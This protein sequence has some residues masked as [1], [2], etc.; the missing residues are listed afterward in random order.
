[1]PTMLGRG[2]CGGHLT[3]VFTIEDSS[4][5]LLW[6]GSRGVGICVEDGVEAIAKGLGGVH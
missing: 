1:M 2:E 3:L 4:D 5:D 6:Q